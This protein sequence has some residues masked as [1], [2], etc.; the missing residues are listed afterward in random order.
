MG[1]YSTIWKTLQW[2]WKVSCQNTKRGMGHYSKSIFRSGS[3]C[4]Q[5]S[6]MQTPYAEHALSKV[7]V[8]P[9]ACRGPCR[10]HY[11][12]CSRWHFLGQSI[13]LVSTHRK[14][15]LGTL[16]KINIFFHQSNSVAPP[17]CFVLIARHVAPSV[18]PAAVSWLSCKP[19]SG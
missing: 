9:A 8:C 15:A 11:H 4:I 14:S 16:Q 1:H 12:C 3:Q 6:P 10:Q 13:N 5:K 7:H 18:C 19:V 17:T 2:R